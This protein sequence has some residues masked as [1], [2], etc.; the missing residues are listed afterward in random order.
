MLTSTS[1]PQLPD[2]GR[3]E[4]CLGRDF[5]SIRSINMKE[6]SIAVV[7]PPFTKAKKGGP[8]SSTISHRGSLLQ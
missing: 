8:E 1:M 3:P 7:T 5:C 6:I 2:S 4:M